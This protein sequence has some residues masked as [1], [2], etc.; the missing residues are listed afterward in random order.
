[1]Q[2]TW[3]VDLSIRRTATEST[4]AKCEYFSAGGSVKDRIAKV[5]T[6]LRLEGVD[7]ESIQR[8][9]EEAEKGGTLVPGQSIV[10]EPTSASPSV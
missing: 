8:M 2:H 9:V 10:I 4:V 5:S 1:V 6:P 3:V 7:T